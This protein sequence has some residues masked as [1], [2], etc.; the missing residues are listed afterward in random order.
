[1]VQRHQ[2]ARYEV[3]GG[4]LKLQRFQKHADSPAHQIA[5]RAF[6][7]GVGKEGAECTE[8]SLLDDDGGAPSFLEW[9]QVLHEPKL[10]AVNSVAATGKCRMMRW[11]ITTAHRRALKQKMRDALCISIQQDMRGNRFLLRLRCVTDSLEILTGTIGLKKH[12][13]SVQAPGSDG[14]REATMSCIKAFCCKEVPPNYGGLRVKNPDREPE[15]DLQFCHMLC[16]RIEAFAADSAADEQLAARELQGGLLA[17]PAVPRLQEELTQFLSSLKSFLKSC[18]VEFM[19]KQHSIAKI[20]TFKPAIKQLYEDFRAKLPDAPCGKDLRYAPQR[21]A[22]ESVTLLRICISFEAVLATLSC[23]PDVRSASS[24]EG[25][26]C[27]HTL[28]WLD[29]EKCLQLGML[30]GRLWKSSAWWRLR[31]RTKRISSSSRFTWS[32]SGRSWASSLLKACA[33]KFLV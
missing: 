7:K 25:A 13:G 33:C 23:V 31:T 17:G 3:H 29:T 11:C 2:F 4:E 14:L 28:Q 27:L 10:H 20:I 18:V 21:Y 19:E 15:L 22:S 32:T 30:G 5:A 16:G 6:S 26:A 12:A 9:K 1:M 8:P 24:D